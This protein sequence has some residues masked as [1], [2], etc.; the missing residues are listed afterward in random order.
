[1]DE[2]APLRRDPLPEVFNALR[3]LTRTGARWRMQPHGLPPWPAVRQ[4]TRRWLAASC[5]DA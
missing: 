3:W 1:M 2:G 5:A 4:L